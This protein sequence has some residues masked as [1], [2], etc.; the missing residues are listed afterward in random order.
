LGNGRRQDKIAGRNPVLEALSAGRRIERVLVAAG[1]KVDDIEAE[2]ARRC[3]RIETV[4]RHYL[5]SLVKTLHQGVVAFAEP[6]EYAVTEDILEMAESRGEPA[7]MVA[8]DQ[9][10]DP[11]NLGSILRSCD[12]FGV[13]GV[14]I[15][16]R[17]A[18]GLG[19]AVSR[20][21]AGA[22]EHVR[23]A[24]VVNM[25]RELDNLKRAGLWVIGLDGDG[26]QILWAVD[27][28]SP[29]VIVVGGE[30]RGLRRLVKEKCDV[31]ARIPM[32]GQVSSLNAGVAAALALY[33]TRRQ[34]DAMIQK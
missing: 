3:V 14:I 24:R 13:H 4:D 29:V 5:D 22:V 27:L 10:E 8:L 23:V 26:D 33:E 30:G 15:L 21:S 11:Q 31:I 34:R 19:P 7:M 18:V 12:A 25:A 16:E 17:R 32:A 1:S 20:A 6:L 9:L 28:T 2:A